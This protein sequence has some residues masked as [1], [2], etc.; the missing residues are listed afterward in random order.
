[1]PHSLQGKMLNT[2]NGGS[3]WKTIQQFFKKSD[4]V[5]SKKWAG[6]LSAKS[7]YLAKRNYCNPVHA[8]MV[9]HEQERETKKK[10]LFFR[11]EEEVRGEAVTPSI[12]PSPP[13]YT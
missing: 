4:T 7:I 11:G 5:N 10:K 12:Y 2:E 3:L 1:M 8:A 9:S 6:I 13:Q